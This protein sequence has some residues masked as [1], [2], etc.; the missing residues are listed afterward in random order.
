LLGRVEQTEYEESRPQKKVP[1]GVVVLTT[2]IVEIDLKRVWT[3]RESNN[4]LKDST[5]NTIVSGIF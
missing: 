2:G 4:P 1:Q 5:S 3:K